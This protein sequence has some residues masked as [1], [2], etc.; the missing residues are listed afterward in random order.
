MLLVTLFA[1]LTYVDLLVARISLPHREAGAYAAASI[2]SRVMFLVA[3]VATTVLF[4]RVAAL[5]DTVRE[6]QHLVLGLGAVTALGSVCCAVAFIFAEPLIV[7]ALGP[8][9]DAAVPWLGW[10]S[11]AMLLFA[12][13]SVFQAH[14]LALGKARYAAVLGGGLVLEIAL[15]AAFHASPQQLIADQ[16]VA[17]AVLLLGSEL[18]D[19]LTRT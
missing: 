8:G 12:L 16:L 4:P 9:Y 15:F 11:L 19:R 18:Y 13:V 2:A 6:R 3:N 1:A 5:A 14:F 7:H 17:G 10:L